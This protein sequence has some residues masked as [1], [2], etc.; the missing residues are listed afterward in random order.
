VTPD[1]QH[2]SDLSSYEL[3][4]ETELQTAPRTPTQHLFHYT[5]AEA[6]I[7]G[8]LPTGTLRLSPYQ[9]TND[10]WES[11]PHYPG[12][13]A[14]HDDSGTDTGFALWDEIDRQLRLHTKV[15]CLTQ[16]LELPSHVASRD[17]LRGWSHL[18]LWAHYGAAHAGVCLRFDRKRLIDAFLE[19]TSPAA[20]AFHGPV[21]Y[22][23]S[24][25]SPA[26]RGIDLGQV[27]EFGADAVAMAYAA[28]NKDQLFF[29]KHLDWQSE[30][31]FRLV[32]LND[33]VDYDF[34]DVRGA[35]TGVVLG[36]A[37]RQEHLPSLLAALE[38]Y[39]DVVL[40][41]VGFHNRR[42]LCVPFEGVIT[43]RP[44]TLSEQPWSA[45]PRRTG[46]LAERLQV[47]R[48]AEAKVAAQ[49]EAA[50]L[51]TQ[52][53]VLVLEQGITAMASQLSWPATEVTVHSHIMA[54]PEP[55]RGRMPGVAG[56]VVHY[57]RGF[58]CVVENVPKHS[59]TLVAAAAVQ[60][61]NDQRLR[62]HAMVTTERWAPDGNTRTEHWR[63]QVEAPA[64]EA[65]EALTGLLAE[66]TCAT[67][68]VR[69][70][71]DHDREAAVEDAE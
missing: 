9:F 10:L 4:L 15:G 19:H 2:S 43:D 44:R 33:S 34:I 45:T 26:T 6:A 65:A 55:Q 52:Q 22:L 64:Q 56:E 25:S 24:Q 17:A 62:L 54:V 8:I 37:F 49:R 18:S 21:T 58:M 16:D 38:P 63:N 3:F 36:S 39:P 66:L 14:H 5:S 32:L 57:E 1:G 48:A 70:S 20:L 7:S 23:S 41:Q 31:E 30:A 29:R 69:T 50:V 28:A 11:Q 59:Y 42:M 68:T 40:E 60:V 47:L 71:F 27:A 67:H 46:S 35:L 53:H 61:L 13:S 51:L 12:L